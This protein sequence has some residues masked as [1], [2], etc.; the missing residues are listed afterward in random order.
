MTTLSLLC[1]FSSSCGEQG[2][3][4][5]CSD[6]VSHCSDFFCGVWAPGHA[7]S[8]AV[9][10]GLLSTGSIDVVLWL[11]CSTACRIFPDQRLNSCLLQW[12]VNSVPLS[13]QGSHCMHAKSLQSCPTFWD[14]T[15]H[16]PPGSSVHRDSPGMNIGVGCYALLIFCIRDWALASCVSHT[17]RWVLFH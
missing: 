12:Q 14:P 8:V 17:G 13:H 9:A 11:S 15:D 2:L 10:P 1:R 5:S 7:C 3:L 16:S 6:Q 4:P